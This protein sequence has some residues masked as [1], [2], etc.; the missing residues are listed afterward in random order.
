MTFLSEG[1]MLGSGL[2]QALSPIYLKE[3]PVSYPGFLSRGV[4]P[5]QNYHDGCLTH[6]L[7]A[8]MDFLC[9]ARWL[10]PMYRPR[11]PSWDISIVLKGLSDAPFETLDSEKC[12]TI[13][14]ALLIAITSLKRVGDLQDL[15]VTSSC[16]DF[17]PGL[18]KVILQPRPDYIPKVLSSPCHPVVLQVFSPPKSGTGEA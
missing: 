13:K 17:A 9:G 7:R 10:R 6:R 3:S 12:L 11:V 16:L 5:S 2:A 14:V 4:L 1:R 8:V 15:S 18:V